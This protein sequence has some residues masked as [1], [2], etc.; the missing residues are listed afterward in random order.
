ML[1]TQASEPPAA[2]PWFYEVKYDGFRALLDI[3]AE[4]S[5]LTS[6][7]GKPLLPQF[8][9]IE[10]FIQ[11]NMNVLQPFLPL[12]LD[13]ELVWL[14]NP[15]K[16]DFESIQL[17]GRIR[18]KDKIENR[19]L[20]S[21]CRL[22]AF[23]VLKEAGKDLSSVPFT[24]RK[25]RLRHLFG[26]LGW[27]MSPD[28][29]SRQLIQYVPAAA[30]PQEIWD[31]IILHDGEG[32]IAKHGDS[33]YLPGKRSSQ[34]LK[35]KNKKTA[36]CF[37]LA[38][39]KTSGYFR[40]GLYRGHEIISIGIVKDGFTKEERQ[41]L[42]SIVKNNC[43]KEDKEF[44]YIEPSICIAVKYLHLYE[45]ELREPHFDSF[46]LNKPPEDC[47]WEDF[48]RQ[49]YHFPE[50]IKVSNPEKLLWDSPALTYSK[51]ELLG[52]LK[53]VSSWFLSFSNHKP[54]T[55][56]RY[57]DGIWEERFFQK[58]CP[59]YAPD[60]IKT[61]KEGSI[62]YIICDKLETLLWLGNMASIEFHLPFQEAGKK[63]PEDLVLDLDP[64]SPEQLPLAVKAA[65]EI[66]RILDTLKLTAFIKTSGN[67][68]L[69]L[70]IPLQRDSY[71]Y[72]DTRLFTDFL[73][74]LLTDLHP[75]EFTVERMKKQ[76]ENRLYLDFVQHAPG[77][78]II[79]PYSPRAN[80]FGG[81]AAPLYWDEVG[82]NLE[83]EHYTVKTVPERLRRE[84][85]PFRGYEE[86]REGQ[87]FEQIVQ[88]LKS[89]GKL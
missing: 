47:T 26:T 58:H 81:V 51:Q 40:L 45:K 16:A 78:T 70:H 56:I 48:I 83:I 41:T 42:A 50:K 64:S 55:V 12:T 36:F 84:G 89:G 77:K 15:L 21:P 27:P 18:T 9:E 68:G 85:C 19:S 63:M 13:A 1:L 8:P 11:E 61:F 6:R 74:R 2:G 17:R 5:R 20:V 87:P 3:E 37:I 53:A 80:N 76:R 38:Y 59:D 71:T 24:Q 54:L 7:N 25:E 10:R 43:M 86:A 62:E 82:E 31:K 46:L 28:P 57:P 39:H 29:L 23:D 67:R 30:Q 79:A 35:I 14:E 34:W 88:F 75:E 65:A 69:Q 60:F 32:M 72:K 52:Y 22:M 66:K 49:S 33:R 44:Y 4:N 73:G